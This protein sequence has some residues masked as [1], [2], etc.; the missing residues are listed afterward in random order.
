MIIQDSY[1]GLSIINFS[2][3][4]IKN[5]MTNNTFVSNWNIIIWTN[6]FID[7]YLQNPQRQ[8]NS[9]QYSVSADLSYVLIAHDHQLYSHNKA[10]STYKLYSVKTRYTFIC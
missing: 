3:N 5:L 7:W 6:F 9:N 2:N 4:Q 8:L 10:H 1:E